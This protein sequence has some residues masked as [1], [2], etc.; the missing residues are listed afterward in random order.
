MPSGVMEAYAIAVSNRAKKE[1]LNE[2]KN[3]SNVQISNM[4][5]EVNDKQALTLLERVA[6]EEKRVEK[7]QNDK[8]V[9][10]V[11]NGCSIV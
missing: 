8:K 10:C 1:Y 11:Q 5:D 9:N 6:T 3:I 4:K 2:Q 7:K